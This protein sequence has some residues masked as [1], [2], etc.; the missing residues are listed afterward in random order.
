MK[1]KIERHIQK[2]NNYAHYPGQVLIDHPD[3]KDLLRT[4]HAIPVRDEP[5]TAMLSKPEIRKSK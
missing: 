4:G 1:I 3:E 2:G 5:E